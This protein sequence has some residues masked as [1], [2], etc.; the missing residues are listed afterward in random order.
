MVG[1]GSH[2]DSLKSGIA[3]KLVIYLFFIQFGHDR[4]RNLTATIY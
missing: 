2:L 3:R 1:L 4:Y